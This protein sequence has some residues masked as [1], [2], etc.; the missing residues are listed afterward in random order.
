VPGLKFESFFGTSAGL[1]LTDALNLLKIQSSPTFSPIVGAIL[2]DV[3][4]G[5]AL[6]TAMSKHPKVFSRVYI[7]L[8][9]A[10]EAAGIMEKIM[11]RLADNSE[12]SREFKSKVVGAMIYPIII[13]VGLVVVMAVMMIVVIP[14]LSELYKDFD[15]ELPAATKIVV[16]ISDFSVQY[17]WAMAVGVVGLF[18]GFRAYINTE[19]GRSVWDD[20]KFKFPIIGPLS[21][22][23]IL[24]EMTRTMSL[25][26]GAGVSVVESLG[27]VSE[28]AGNVVVQR[29]LKRI[30]KQVEKGFPLSISFSESYIFPPLIGQ[31]IAVG[32][33]TGKLDDVMIKLST[34]FESES[35]EKVKGLTSAIEPII[36][37]VLAVGV[38]FL[39][40]AIIVPIYGITNQF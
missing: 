8:V 4:S 19:S 24:T 5:V 37:I 25:L 35:S 11:M 1:P 17:W 3:Q 34:Y 36:L 13:L 39:M 7:A 27:I 18:F 30:A 20:F 6:S 16:A 26:V 38:G 14:K 22:Q 12:K 15:A 10:G 28:A 33:E 29:E 21:K 2:S 32:E 23:V 40:Y 31:M 9:R